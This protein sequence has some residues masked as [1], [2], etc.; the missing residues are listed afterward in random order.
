M[1]GYKDTY[2]EWYGDTPV[3]ITKFEQTNASPGVKIDL[4][5]D[6]TPTLDNIFVRGTTT[7]NNAL[8]DFSD[9]HSRTSISRD[10]R[11]EESN[12]SPYRLNIKSLPPTAGNYFVEFRITDS[13]GRTKNYHLILY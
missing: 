9:I 5:K 11:D 4:V 13:L 2:K 6:G 7:I 10:W 3:T 1:D 8:T 12:I